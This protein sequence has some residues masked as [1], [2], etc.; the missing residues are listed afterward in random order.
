[1]II[2]AIKISK[3]NHDLT[4]KKLW[5]ND[6]NG[7]QGPTLK[8]MNNDEPTRYKSTLAVLGK[9]SM[10]SG[11]TCNCNLLEKYLTLRYITNR[12]IHS[13]SLPRAALP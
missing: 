11:S 6:Y 1:M 12:A 10:L 13:L 9:I 5:W 3:N 2:L 8:H 7:T 4:I